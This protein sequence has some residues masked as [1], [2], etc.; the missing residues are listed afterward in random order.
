MAR[1]N[2][3]DCSANQQN[4]QRFASEVAVIR[5]VI[6][7]NKKRLAPLTGEGV[8]ITSRFTFRGN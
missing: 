5:R 3:R 4:R 8:S 2:A 7:G 1:E 6:R